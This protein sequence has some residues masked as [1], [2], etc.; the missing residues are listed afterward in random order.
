MQNRL[1][2]GSITY[3]TM[4]FWMIGRQGTNENNKVRE[5]DLE[6]DSFRAEESLLQDSC[7][8]FT[9]AGDGNPSYDPESAP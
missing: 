9:G 8:L 2:C 3:I 5:T 4:Q 7:A 6:I 1:R